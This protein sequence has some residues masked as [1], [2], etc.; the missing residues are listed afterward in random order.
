MGWL[1]AVVEKR[2]KEDIRY[3]RRDV[4]DEFIHKFEFEAET[5]GYLR[6]RYYYGRESDSV[7]YSLPQLMQLLATPSEG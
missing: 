7:V 1:Q 6:V 5:D 2:V 3:R 4:D